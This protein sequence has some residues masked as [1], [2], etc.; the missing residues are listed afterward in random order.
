MSHKFRAITQVFLIPLG[1]WNTKIK[2][3]CVRILVIQNVPGSRSNSKST[4][5][6]CN[7]PHSKQKI[8]QDQGHYLVYKLSINFL[9]IRLTKMKNCT[10]RPDQPYRDIQRIFTYFHCIYRKI[11]SDNVFKNDYKQRKKGKMV[12]ST[13]KDIFKFLTSQCSYFYYQPSE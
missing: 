6:S 10:R 5:P 12:L 7:K 2:V 11:Q 8:R 9:K 4:L 13:K 1:P 3:L